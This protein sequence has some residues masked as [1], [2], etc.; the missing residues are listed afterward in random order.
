MVWICPFGSFYIGI[1]E[2]DNIAQDVE[3]HRV[4][5]FSVLELHL[6]TEGHAFGALVF[7]LLEMDRIRASIQR[8]KF[9]LRGAVILISDCLSPAARLA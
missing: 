1:N 5:A 4:A 9:V 3:K 2:A 8:L 6:T 7:H